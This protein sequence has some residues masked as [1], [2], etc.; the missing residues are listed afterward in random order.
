MRKINRQRCLAGAGA[1]TDYG[2]GA[3]RQAFFEHAE[4]T[5]S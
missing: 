3:G 2:R 5:R 4:Q 1:A